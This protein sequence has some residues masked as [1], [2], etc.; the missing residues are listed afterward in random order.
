MVA[1]VNATKV[2]LLLGLM[3]WGGGCE[4][5]L[6]VAPPTIVVRWDTVKPADSRRPAAG[7]TYIALVRGDI[8]TDLS[9]KVGGILERIG[10]PNGADWQE[11]ATFT[12]NQPLAQLVQAD[13]T[14]A[15]NK[16]LA[17]WE[18]DNS[19]FKR[20]ST[21]ISKG[22]ISSNEFDV[23]TARAKESAAALAQARQAL[24]DSVLRAPY[25]GTIL[26]RSAEAGETI[27]P[28]HPLLHIGDLRQMSLEFGVPDAV[29]G[30]IKANDTLPITISALGEMTCTG[31]VSE[32]GV[33]ARKGERLFKVVLKVP[34]PAGRLK[35]GMTASV[36]LAPRTQPNGP[37]VQAPLSALVTRTKISD[38]A[39]PFAVFVLVTDGAKTRVREQPVAIGDLTDNSIVITNGLS[40]GDK[41]VVVGASMLYDDAPVAARPAK[42]MLTM[43][44]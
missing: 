29:V 27:P 2:F 5:K 43:G 8:E 30:H 11:G 42:E 37:A 9:F 6:P 19:L 35:S 18:M 20:S 15:L 13:F 44:R 16:A 24:S 22:V 41:V 38:P 14:N 32:V 17:N 34:N 4:R 7:S 3:C 26:A 12:N 25:D 33:A 21:L 1:E 28:G 40:A 23:I 10:N 39:Q 36:L 31:R